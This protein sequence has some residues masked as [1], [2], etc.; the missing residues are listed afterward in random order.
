MVV[1]QQKQ[2]GLNA[3]KI[4]S[5][6]LKCSDFVLVEGAGSDKTLKKIQVLRKGYAEKISCPTE[7]LVALVSDFDIKRD[8]PRFHPDDVEK[9]SDFLENQ[10]HEKEP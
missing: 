1:F 7:E 3:R 2:T 4:S 10:P 8:K 6:Y 5:E 9:I